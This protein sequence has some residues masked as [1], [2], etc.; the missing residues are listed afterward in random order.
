MLY[1][2]Y[3][4]KIVADHQCEFHC[5]KSTM[6]HIF[7]ICQILEERWEYNGALHQLFI[8]FKKVCDLFM[9]EVLYNIHSEC[10]IPMK[11]G[12]LIKICLNKMWSPCI[13]CSEWSETGI[14][15]SASTFQLCFRT[16]LKLGASKKVKRDWNWMVHVSSGPLRV[17]HSKR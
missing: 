9:R 2:I 3:L 15:F 4:G 8:D 1:N 13:S 14:C 12:R 17:I 16:H 7:C 11:L 5:D 6:H 10:C